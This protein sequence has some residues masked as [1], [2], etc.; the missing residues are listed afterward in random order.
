MG[1]NKT[2]GVV[3][4]ASKFSVQDRV[5]CVFFFF[6]NGQESLKTPN[7]VLVASESFAGG[8]GFGGCGGVRVRELL[9]RGHSQPGLRR[10]H[11]DEGWG[12]G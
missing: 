10:G 4:A 7:V 3:A 9:L 8:E 6:G 11:L 1:D 2:V 5:M 12:E